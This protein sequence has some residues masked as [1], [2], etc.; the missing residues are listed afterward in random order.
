MQDWLLDFDV[1]GIFPYFTGRR[2]VKQLRSFFNGSLSSIIFDF[3]SKTY[4]KHNYPI[5]TQ[6]WLLDFDISGIFPCLTGRRKF[7]EQR[8]FLNGSL[9]SII[10]DL[11]SKFYKKHKLSI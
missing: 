11:N 1:S 9:S 5:L 10:F 6:Y 2:K 3:N 4:K 8:S 7:K